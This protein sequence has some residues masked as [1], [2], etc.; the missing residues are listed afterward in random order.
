MPPLTAVRGRAGFSRLDLLGTLSAVAVLGLVATAMANTQRITPEW[1]LCMGNLRQLGEAWRSHGTDNTL[2][3][4][5]PSGAGQSENIA[6]SESW[7]LG[8]LDWT[9]APDNTNQLKIQIPGFVRYTGADPALFRCP[10]DQYVS[11]GQRARGWRYRTRSYSM[12]GLVNLTGTDILPPG[13]MRFRTLSDF[14]DPAGTFVFTEEHPDSMNDAAILADP[15]GAR[16]YDLPA[17]FHD[18]GTV[19][20]FADGHV[21]ARR[22]T[23][24]RIPQ[25]VRVGVFNIPAG[26]DADVRWLGE[27][28][29]QRIR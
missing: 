8:W 27:R 23:G 20:A 21:E 12:N 24:N 14:S 5:N 6:L 9:T 7:A 11:A 25:P 29:S 1:L 26:T 18:G 16:L 13:F 3:L 4:R 10:S 28:A 22:W 19:F 17:T 2:L 15:T